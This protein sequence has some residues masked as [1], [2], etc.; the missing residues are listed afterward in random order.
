[1]VVHPEV[2]WPADCRTEYLDGYHKLAEDMKMRV[3]ANKT[4][5]SKFDLK[6]QRADDLPG[7]SNHVSKSEL[8]LKFRKG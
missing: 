2:S 5:Y 7:R 8:W 4:C 6:F 1:M 3:L